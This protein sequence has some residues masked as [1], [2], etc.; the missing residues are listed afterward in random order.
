MITVLAGEEE[1]PFLIHREKICSC[2]PVV[3]NACT[4]SWIEA[5]ERTVWLPHIP[6]EFFDIYAEWVYA[7]SVSNLDFRFG[8]ASTEPIVARVSFT[9]GVYSEPTQTILAMAN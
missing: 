4:G 2:S 8:R 6:S 3:R 9:T 7:H 5:R 1:T